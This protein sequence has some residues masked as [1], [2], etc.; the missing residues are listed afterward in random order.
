METPVNLTSPTARE[1]LD[2]QYQR[3]DV[4]SKSTETSA[5]EMLYAAQA[6]KQLSTAEVFLQLETAILAASDAKQSEENI[7]QA[8]LDA[9]TAL[10]LANSQ[11]LVSDVV[12]QLNAEVS[13]VTDRAEE[14]NDSLTA[15]ASTVA[16][17]SGQVL[18][19]QQDITVKHAAVIQAAETVDAAILAAAGDLLT[20]NAGELVSDAVDAITSSLVEIENNVN[21]KLTEITD[22]TTAGTN[23][24]ALARA[25]GIAAIND[26]ATAATTQAV[27]TINSAATSLAVLG[28]I[29]KAASGPLAP[30]DVWVAD[31]RNAAIARTLPTVNVPL[32]AEIKIRDRFG[33]GGDNAITVNG[34]VEGAT[35]L[36]LTGDFQWVTLKWDGTEYIIIA[37]S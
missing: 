36:S 14:L 10:V 30:Y 13:A 31:S 12:Q 11:A 8:V 25:Q 24:I 4:I 37:C 5:N 35:F 17:Q 32:N 16:T 27:T 20:E 18:A 6:L 33:S 34:P 15:I 21:G 22:A 7:D 1:I 9:A 3:L 23:A 26:A 2:S 28:A 29:T 19:A